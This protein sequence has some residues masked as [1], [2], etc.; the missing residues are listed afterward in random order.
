MITAKVGTFWYR[1]PELMQGKKYNLKVDAWALGLV[2]I[3]LWNKTRANESV[4]GG[5]PAVVEWF[6]SK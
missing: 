5:C 6:P 2:I 4:S 3:E 1:A